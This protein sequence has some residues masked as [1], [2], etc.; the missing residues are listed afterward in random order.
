[1]PGK[2]LPVSAF[3]T[4]QFTRGMKG[5]LCWLGQLGLLVR[6]LLFM[7]CVA[8]RLVYEVTT[9]WGYFA[10][11]PKLPPGDGWNP[12]GFVKV[13]SARQCTSKRMLAATRF[14]APAP[15]Y[16]GQIAY[17]PARNA[18]A[19]SQLDSYDYNRRCM[20]LWN[21]VT[22]VFFLSSPIY[23]VIADNN[24]NDYCSSCLAIYDFDYSE[25]SMRDGDIL[26]MLHCLG[27]A[28]LQRGSGAC[29]RWQI[30][31]LAVLLQLCR[32]ARDGPVRHTPSRMRWSSA[33]EHHLL[34]RRHQR[35]A[36]ASRRHE[37]C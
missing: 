33:Q 22:S 1:M 14:A 6:L 37:Y 13:E 27:A 21:I 23:F 3:M 16:P 9:S 2:P 12:F 28:R 15:S 30:C 7:C 19:L 4:G 8:D 29:A 25:V 10:D 31:F 18:V 26:I 17:V 32:R 20:Q 5:R 24:V 36:D 11:F 35:C 34:D